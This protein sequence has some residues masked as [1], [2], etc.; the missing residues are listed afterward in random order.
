VGPAV[1]FSEWDDVSAK[2]F[3]A[4]MRGTVLEADRPTGAL[5]STKQA[6]RRQR[7][8][9][10]AMAMLEDR[11]FERIQVKDIADGASVALGTVYHYFSSKEHLF[12][13]VLVQW[14]G[15]LRTSITRRSL[16]GADPAA[17]LEDA[18]HRSVRAFER[19]PPLARLVARLQ[20]SED[21]FAVD[22]LARLD[23]VTNEVYLAAL[24]DLEPTVA[25]RVVRVADAV[26]DSSLRS[27]S[28]GRLPIADVYRSLSDAVA[29][30]LGGDRGR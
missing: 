27:W 22:V 26:L 24:E 9:D 8:V 3:D 18:L 2:G 6:A 11:E 30:L 25:A 4:V 21:P 17:R 28:A 16:A 12:G 1:I 7:I 23:A 15:S 10:A 14:A 20:V 13:E 5:L 29:L 19:R